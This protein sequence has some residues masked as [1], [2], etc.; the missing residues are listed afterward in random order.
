MISS[1]TLSKMAVMVG[2]SKNGVGQAQR[3]RRRIGQIFHLPRHVI[4]QIAEQAGGHGRQALRAR[5][6]A[7]SRVSARNDVSGLAL[8]GVKLFTSSCRRCG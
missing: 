5:P 4:A 8:S 2:R 3:V 1:F 7:S 6:V